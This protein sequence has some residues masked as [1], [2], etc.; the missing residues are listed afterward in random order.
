MPAHSKAPGCP[1]AGPLLLVGPV[2]TSSRALSS[3]A[4]GAPGLQEA[5]KKSVPVLPTSVG[6]AATPWALGRSPHG[7]PVGSV[8]PGRPCQ[9][10]L[11]GDQ[12]PLIAAPHQAQSS[13][14]LAACPGDADFPGPGS[15]SRPSLADGVRARDPRMACSP[16]RQGQCHTHGDIRPASATRCGG[17]PCSAWVSPGRSGEGR[18]G[19]D[20]RSS[21]R[22]RRVSGVG[23][24][25]ALTRG[26]QV[27]LITLLGGRRS[28]HGLSGAPRGGRTGGATPCRE[29][30]PRGPVAPGQA[31]V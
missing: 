26:Q 21:K 11:G 16:A 29:L 14:P 17:C 25:P 15:R 31:S 9:A 3:R 19:L 4:W 13:R 1:C 23:T 27:Q 30:G 5:P 8:S 18:G 28:S 20:P 10:R 22:H 2:F 6:R 12:C 24:R 7:L